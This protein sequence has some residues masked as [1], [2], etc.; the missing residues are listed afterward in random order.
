MAA[1]LA[2]HGHGCSDRITGGFCTAAYKG[3]TL[4]PLARMMNNANQ[5]RRLLALVDIHDGGSRSDAARIG[6][7]CLQIVR[8][9]VVR[10]NAREPDRP[11]DGKV[12]GERPR[13]NDAQ[14]Q[15]FVAIVE[16]GPIPAIHS[17]RSALRVD[18]R[19]RKPIGVPRMSA[20]SRN[21][22]RSEIALLQ[23]PPQKTPTC[24]AFQGGLVKR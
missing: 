14:R 24:P 18:V 2:G 17:L 23:L 9:W 22:P 7:V 3:A 10:F 1:G 11:I 16:S 5:S 6:G 15:A 12:P 13:L 20:S 4:K 19:F 21:Q 8:D